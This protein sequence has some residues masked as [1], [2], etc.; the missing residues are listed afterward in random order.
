[1]A[2]RFGDTELFTFPVPWAKFQDIL[3]EEGVRTQ[4][5][6]PVFIPKDSFYRLY[7]LGTQTE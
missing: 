1:M 3:V 7:V 4:I 6:S 5:Q 2:I